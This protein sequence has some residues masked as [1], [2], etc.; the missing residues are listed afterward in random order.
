MALPLSAGN[1]VIGALTVQSVEEAAFSAGDATALQAMA[2]QLTV[3]I[4]NARLLQKLESA[5]KELVQ[6][7]T[8][9][10]IATATGEAIHWVGN[11]AAPIPGSVARITEEVSFATDSVIVKQA[12]PGDA[13]F[14]VLNGSVSVR[15]NDRPVA[16]LGQGECFGEMALLDNEPRSADVVAADDTDLLRIDAQSFDELLEQK[17]TIVKSIF[18]VLSTRLRKATVSSTTLEVKAVRKALE[19]QAGG[20][21][22]KPDEEN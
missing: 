12:D 20:Q 18:K 1:E 22:G 7:K 11:K 16:R 14:L 19:E 21:G 6:A 8:F 9:E 10:A 2:D 15:V 13:M 5:H 17:H 4:N 3:A